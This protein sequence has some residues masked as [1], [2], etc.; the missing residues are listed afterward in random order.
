ME[1]RMLELSDLDFENTQ[2]RTKD[3]TLVLFHAAWCPYCRNLMPSFD[4]FSGRARVSVGKVDI[5]D[6]ESPLWDAFSI[7]AVP[8]AILFEDGRVADRLDSAIGD[9]ISP[10]EFMEFAERTKSI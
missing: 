9:G 5:S 7:E 4:S 3:R 10:S 1:R 2:L 8:T 6:Y